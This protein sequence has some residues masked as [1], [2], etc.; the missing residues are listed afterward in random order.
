MNAVKAIFLKE[1]RTEFR[2]KQMIIFAL[3]LSLMI[4]ASFR[5]AFSEINFSLTELASPIIWVTF[6]F[7]GM[8]SLAPTYKKEVEQG[9]K[10][11]LLLAPIP[12][13]SIYLGKFLA[14]F[15]VIM[16]LELFSLTL[17]FIFFPV[18]VPDLLALMTIIILGTIGFTALGNLISAISSNLSQSE[19]MLPVLLVPIMLFTVVM[20]SVSSTSEIFSGANLNGVFEGIKL[21]LSFDIVF[22]ASGYL[23]IDYVL[24]D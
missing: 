10:D 4:L 13:S 24:E 19:V 6:F 11:G 2:N 18:P 14:N 12:P 1:L 5:F 23:L 20:T 3:I 17:F 16:G 21:I 9:T 15:L 22:L 8:F 7:S